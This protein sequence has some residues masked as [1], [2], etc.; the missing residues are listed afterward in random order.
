MMRAWTNQAPI[1]MDAELPVQR[2]LDAYNDRDLAR[3][4]ACYSDDVQIFRPPATEPVMCGK[5]AMAAHDAA[6]RFH[7]PALHA[8]LVNRMVLGDKVVDH[9]RVSGVS[10]LPFEAAVVYQVQG[11]LITHVWFFEAT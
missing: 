7:L 8:E 3:F 2:Q 10:E 4:T 11:A 5:A 9:E 1:A 6:K